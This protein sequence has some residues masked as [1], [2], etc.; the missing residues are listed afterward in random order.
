MQFEWDDRKAATNLWKHDVSF[1][2]ASTVFV[3]PREIFDDKHSVSEDRFVAVGISS[4][5]RR[6]FVSDSY[7][8][9]KIRII[10][11]RLL[12]LR[13]WNQYAQNNS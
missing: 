12:T 8:E 2:E 1:D 6:L 11:A 5:G 7:R 13:E 10:M 9:G 4:R 3:Q